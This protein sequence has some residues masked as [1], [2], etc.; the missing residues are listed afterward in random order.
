MLFMIS[1]NLI[2]YFFFKQKAAYEMRICD[3]SS[4]VC[5]S[6]LDDPLLFIE[7]IPA[8]E[9]RVYVERVLTNLWIYRHRLGQPTPG[10]DAVAAG[11]WPRYTA[12]DP[13]REDVAFR[14]N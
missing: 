10:L 5:S 4:D 3:W 9:T 1:S 14:G 8:R 13:L 12:L 11:E 6:D 2:W 7:S